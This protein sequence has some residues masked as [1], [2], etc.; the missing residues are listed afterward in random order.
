[1]LGRQW[2]KGG[3][4]NVG[5]RKTLTERQKEFCRLCAAGI[6]PWDAVKKLGYK[7]IGKTVKA[8]LRSEKVMAELEKERLRLQ[9]LPETE[10]TVEKTLTM[11]KA[12]MLARNG[13]IQRGP[14]VKQVRR[15]AEQ[16]AEKDEILC[17]LTDVM[18]N[19]DGADLKTR[20]KAAELLGKRESLFEKE[21][22]KDE[23]CRVVIVD[24][25]P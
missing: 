8:M 12:A 3:D 11:G 14:M 25:I 13:T 4:A 18:R 6:E 5:E 2:E 17:F 9:K 19:E 23:G 22:G 21:K 15:R 16:A 10:R 24:D 7:N 1:M 20:M